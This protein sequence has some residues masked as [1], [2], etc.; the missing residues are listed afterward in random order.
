MFILWVKTSPSVVVGS[1]SFAAY[2]AKLVGV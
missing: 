1:D 2:S